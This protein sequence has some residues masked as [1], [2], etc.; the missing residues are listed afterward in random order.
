[1]EQLGV[2]EI[3][4]MFPM[5]NLGYYSCCSW[6]FILAKLL[7]CCRGDCHLGSS[8]SCSWLLLE[9]L[10]LMC[11]EVSQLEDM[12]VGAIPEEDRLTQRQL[13]R[14]LSAEH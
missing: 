9:V 3:V 1:M 6:H 10:V 14:I 4:S 2:K 11:P 7:W 5:E 8:F 12:N 13:L